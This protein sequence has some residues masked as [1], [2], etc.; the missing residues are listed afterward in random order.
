MEKNYILAE[1]EKQEILNTLSN[2][3][4]NIISFESMLS[5]CG[6]NNNYTLE[7]L[8]NNKDGI[9]TKVLVNN[10][11]V[12]YILENPKEYLNCFKNSEIAL[13]MLAT[14]ENARR[15]IINNEIWL[16]E[17][18]N[19]SNVEKFDENMT[20]IPIM[21]S[22]NTPKGEVIVAGYRDPHFPYQAFDNNIDTGFYNYKNNNDFL[23]TYKF[24]TKKVI[25]KIVVTL[26]SATGH[27]SKNFF[28]IYIS[29][30]ESGDNWE[31][32]KS[33]EWFWEGGTQKIKNEVV[34]LKHPKQIQR[35]KIYTRA[36]DLDSVGEDFTHVIRKVQA[37]GI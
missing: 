14:T 19:S 3:S 17:I 35:I 36:K 12:N 1:K 34:I 37:Y 18:Q 25:Y 33:D 4:N 16:D 20:T 24:D 30:D 8:V 10:E 7:D 22:N 29:S 15:K 32:I 13:E 27:N 6:I 28:N 5:L 2:F 26:S 11:A 21:T 31:E 9:L 23:L